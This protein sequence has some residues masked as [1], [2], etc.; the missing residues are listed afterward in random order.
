LPSVF[1]QWDFYSIISVGQL[2]PAAGGSLLSEVIE[3][4]GNDVFEVGE[5][6]IIHVS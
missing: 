4:F 3:D 2:E 1:V 6:P 5:E